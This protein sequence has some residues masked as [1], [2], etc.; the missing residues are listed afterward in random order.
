MSG[1]FYEEL[2]VG[3]RFR[4]ANGRTLTEMDNTLFSML[5]MNPQPLHTNADFA[6]K[7]PFG[8]R[9]VN[10]LF[11]LGLVTGLTVADLTDGTIIANLGYDKVIHPNPAFHGD[12]IYAESEVLE[13]R[14]SKSRPEAGIVRLKHW[15]KKP[16]GTVVVEFERTVLFLRREEEK[17][18]R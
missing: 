10:G 11:T 2:E 13:K 17:R 15:G 6:A 8:Q 16:D 5:T 18:R 7:T 4:H 1:K 9:I 3:Q 12:T 14:A